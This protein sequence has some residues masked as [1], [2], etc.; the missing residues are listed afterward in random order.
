M[1]QYID[2][3]LNRFSM[4]TVVSISLIILFV[5][6]IVMALLGQIVYSPL[7]ML[8]SAVVLLG[9][10][11]LTSLLC[12]V[13]F[14]VRIQAESSFITGMILALIFTPTLELAGLATLAAVGV[15]AGA[16]K[17][18]LAWK[19][20]HI[21]NPVAAGAFIAS[22][23]GIAYASW[24]VATPPLFLF[25]LIPAF[26]ILYKTRRLAMGG[27]FVLVATIVLLLVFA[28]YGLEPL[29][30][31]ALLLS[32]PLLF[33][34][35]FM[36]SEP[37]TMPAKRS[38]QIIEA[39]LV[40]ILFALPLSIGSFEMTP[41]LALLI[42]NLYAFVV[43]HRR[44]IQLVF[45]EM[46]PLTP[47]SYELV[48]KP[49]KPVHYEAGQYMELT[50]HHPGK[51]FRGIRRVFSITSA[52]GDD[53][54]RFGVK[55]YEPSSTFKKALHNLKNGDLVP[56]TSVN[57]DFLL[58]NDVK[59]PLL[60]IAGGI[61]ITPFIG[62]LRWLIKQKQQR[63]IIVVYAVSSRAELAYLPVL[64]LAGVP[65]VVV[66]NDPGVSSEKLTAVTAPFIRADI[67]KEHIPDIAE[68]TAYLSG[69][70]GLIGA[71]KPALRQ[72]KVAGLKTDYFTGY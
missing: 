16:S 38:Q 6:A 70:P 47:T 22:V 17:F 19:G 21:F 20:R 35:G 18:L 27:V 46:V 61:G 30:S 67:L 28:G 72:L 51:D 53:T 32:W 2:R 3:I 14:G 31:A 11:Y 56:A 37:L 63:D 55:F 13:L 23:L 42:G 10:V 4:Y 33:F 45:Q 60:L 15:F 57:G 12:G 5:V 59:K 64:K 7:A 65:V 24:L 34:A 50:L 29:E 1:S 54:I 68:R 69:P 66:S 43:S 9:A 25:I 62:Q 58:S 48:F 49:S 39:V 41:V 26:L 71:V 44:S 40:G 8:A 52:P 36:L